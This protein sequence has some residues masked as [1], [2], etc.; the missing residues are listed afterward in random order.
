MSTTMGR[1]AEADRDAVFIRAA[2]AEAAAAV[3]KLLPLCESARSKPA[4]TI[5]AADKAYLA[6]GLMLALLRRSLK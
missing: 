2:R 5:A 6:I 1:V 4:A 3:R